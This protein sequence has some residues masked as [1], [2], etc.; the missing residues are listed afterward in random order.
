MLRITVVEQTPEEVVL[1]VEGRVC[2]GN[3]ALL[4]QEGEGYLKEAG[5]LVL[6]L[7]GVQF[8][9]EA[10]AELLRRWAGEGV[11]MRGGSMFVQAMLKSYGLA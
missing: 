2:R 6:D 11:K 9:D 10:G 5:R 8:I 1:K 7:G 4:E 3:V